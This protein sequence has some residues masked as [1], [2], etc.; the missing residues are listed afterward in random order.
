VNH[1]PVDFFHAI[2]NAIIDYNNNENERRFLCFGS[3]RE[4]SIFGDGDLRRADLELCFSPGLSRIIFEFKLGKEN[5]EQVIGYANSLN[6]SLIVSVAK[7]IKK[8][9][10]SRIVQLTWNDLFNGLL[11]IASSEVSEKL[12]PIDLIEN[13]SP[14]FPDRRLGEPALAFL[15]DFLFTIRDEN[16]VPFKGKRVMVVT[17]KMASRTTMNHNVYWFG[18]NWDK[19]FQF[20]VVVNESQIQYVGEVKERYFRID[21]L[22]EI[23]NKGHRDLIAKSFNDEENDNFNGQPILILKSL[24]NNNKVGLKYIEKG[25]ITQSHRYFDNLELV[26]KQFKSE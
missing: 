18:N 17:G 26:Y 1:L 3:G 24:I 8:I 20:L 7:E 13:F 16:L 21:D 22:D 25:A 12:I 11:K 15:E 10:D 4:R 19:D 14:G 9:N 6:D 23:S 5:Q 2:T